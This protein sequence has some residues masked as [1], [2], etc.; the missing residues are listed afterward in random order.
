M[1]ADLNSD[2]TAYLPYFFPARSTKLVCRCECC[3]FDSYVC[4]CDGLDFS[5]LFNTHTSHACIVL[6]YDE[7]FNSGS[8]TAQ[9][10]IIASLICP[11]LPNLYS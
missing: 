7:A 9:R 6:I 2:K 4:K 11:K 3:T 1:L 5:Q 10:C 8:Q